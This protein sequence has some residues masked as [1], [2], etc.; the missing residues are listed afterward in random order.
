MRPTLRQMEYIVT[1]HELGSFSL[2]AETL[3]VS[4]P[5][6]SNQVAGVEAE[7]G[8]RLFERGRTGAQTT[9]RGLEFVTRARRILSEVAALRATMLSDLPFGGRLR[10]G[11]LPSIGPYLLPQA[12]KA[13]H[14]AQPELRVIVRE[15]NTLNLDEGLRNGR[16]DA[17]IS[18]PEDH[19][20]SFQHRL[21]VEPL[22]VAVA[23]DHPL[24]ERDALSAADL[25]GQR[26]LTLDTGHRLARIVY[27]IAGAS[28]ALVSDDYEGTSLDSIVLMA[29]TGAGIGI[30]PDLFARR[31]GVHRSEVRVMPLAMPDADRTISLL[32]PADRSDR[33]AG[34]LAAILRGAAQGLE[35]DVREG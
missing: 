31:Q 23:R 22:W 12:M 10:L 4:Q 1:V 25:A 26:L 17:I 6:L 32:V 19:P 7:L 33:L 2:A 29:A 35:L 15:E 21:F 3:N 16:F 5:S 20:N 13:L 28:G 9:A 14:A 11:A 18:T 27:G 34:E 30:L 8:V 24:A